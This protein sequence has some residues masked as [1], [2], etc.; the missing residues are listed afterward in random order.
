MFKS[1]LMVGGGGFSIQE[2]VYQS[3]SN[4]QAIDPWLQR[5]DQNAQYH[6]LHHVPSDSHE[7]IWQ[8]AS[9]WGFLHYNNLAPCCNKPTAAYADAVKKCRHQG[10]I[11]LLAG[12][13]HKLAVKCSY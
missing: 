9:K 3:F 11:F 4:D 12:T 6:A 2:E 10:F 5:I 1:G 7:S 13:S 8:A